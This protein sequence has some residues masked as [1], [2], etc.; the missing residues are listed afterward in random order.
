MKRLKLMSIIA[1]KVVTMSLSGVAVAKTEC[2]PARAAQRSFTIYL[3][4]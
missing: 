3:V 2:F 1:A 4:L